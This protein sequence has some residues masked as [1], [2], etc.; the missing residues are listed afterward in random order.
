MSAML[1][2]FGNFLLPLLVGGA[3][4]AFPRL[5]NICS[6]C[7]VPLLVICSLGGLVLFWQ[8]YLGHSFFLGVAYAEEAFTK[9]QAQTTWYSIHHLI[10][11]HTYFN[12]SIPVFKLGHILSLHAAE[13]PSMHINMDVLLE[14]HRAARIEC[15]LEETVFCPRNRFRP[16]YIYGNFEHTLKNVASS[17]FSSIL[18]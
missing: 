10:G 16:E 2:G 14:T 9:E 8:H 5:N 11:L 4:M 13:F 18:V 7:T 17:L 12:G 15:S 3:D 1:G 6:W